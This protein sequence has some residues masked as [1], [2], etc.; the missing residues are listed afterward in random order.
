MGQS[1]YNLRESCVWF[2]F[3]VCWLWGTGWDRNLNKPAL[4]LQFTSL[5]RCFIISYR[6]HMKSAVCDTRRMRQNYTLFLEH[7]AG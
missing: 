6:D 7:K 5:P 3:G 2:F 1:V 4:M